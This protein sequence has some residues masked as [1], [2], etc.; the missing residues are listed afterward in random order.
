[1]L[2]QNRAHHWHDL[3][4]TAQRANAGPLSSPHLKT[5]ER[6]D[7]PIIRTY[8]RHPGNQVPEAQMIAKVCTIKFF[9]YL[10][11]SQMSSYFLRLQQI[12]NNQPMKQINK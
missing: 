8:Q 6:L 10:Y 7:R 5:S 4:M 12:F 2:A 11:S 9:F 1:M 3:T